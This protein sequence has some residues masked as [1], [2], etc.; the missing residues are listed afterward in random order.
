MR[1]NCFKGSP[2]EKELSQGGLIDTLQWNRP[3]EKVWLP[4]FSLL[5]FLWQ[6]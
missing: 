5:L 4:D 2:F 3:K 1:F 6:L